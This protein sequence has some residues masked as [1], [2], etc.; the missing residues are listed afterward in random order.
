ML[1]SLTTLNGGFMSITL[2]MILSRISPP[3]IN[4]TTWYGLNDINMLIMPLKEKKK[5]KVGFEIKKFNL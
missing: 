5:L 2:G 4:A 3:N 1:A